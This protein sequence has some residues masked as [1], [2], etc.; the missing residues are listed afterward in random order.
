[1]G[2]FLSDQN[3]AGEQLQVAG[4]PASLRP[5]PAAFARTPANTTD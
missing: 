2:D 5:A 4:S 1:M 3:D